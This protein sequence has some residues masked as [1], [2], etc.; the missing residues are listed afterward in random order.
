ML[1][2]TPKQYLTIQSRTILEHT[3]AC[4]QGV[5]AVSGILVVHG[6]GDSYWQDIEMRLLAS[7]VRAPFL[8]ST[9]GGAERSDTVMMGLNYLSEE[10]GLN[11]DQWVMVHDAAR[12]CLREH[13]LMELLRLRESGGDG[14]ILASSVKDTMK[15]ATS[16]NQLISHTESREK[17]WHALTP[18]LFR[19]GALQSAFR[20]VM[21]DPEVKITDEASAMEYAGASVALVEGASDNIKLT[22]P[23]D[24]PLIEFLLQQ[25]ERSKHV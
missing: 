14:G 11:K 8:Q 5:D 7:G 23:S 13:D 17:L 15:R 9:V 20:S 4:F 3:I 18:Q 2:E 25:K 22:T 19:L 1:S 21:H 16:D 6:A 24:L 12:P 10:M